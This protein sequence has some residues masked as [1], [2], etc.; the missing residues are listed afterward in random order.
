M[1]RRLTLCALVIGLVS[2]GAAGGAAQTL[3]QRGFA[4]ARITLFP[5][6]T[7]T[8]RVRAMADVMVREEVF[9][10]PTVWL[11]LAAGLDLRQNT[12]DQV[13][14]R[15]DIGDRGTLRPAASVR[16]LAATIARG[17]FTI[18]I[19]K[20][21]IRWGKADIVTPTD[22]FAPRDF[23]NVIDTEF[24]GVS[25]AR[26]VVQLG[27]HTVDIVW[28]RFTPSRIPI[29][30]Q[31][32]AQVS[33]SSV[34]APATGGVQVPVPVDGIEAAIPDGSQAGVRYSRIGRIEYSLSV[35]DGF[36]YLPNIE[37]VPGP[38][39]GRF[40]LLRRYPAMRS[41]GGDAG[42][43]MRYFTVKA[44]AAYSTSDTPATDD[45][46]LYVVQLE[47]L[48]GEWQFAGGYAGEVVTARRAAATF[49]PDRGLTR[50]I[51]ARA[52]YTIDSNRSVA[53][54]GAARQNGRGV[55]TKVEYSQARGQHWRGTIT[56]VIIA[57][58]RD[59]F[60]G[61]YNRNSHVAAGLRYSF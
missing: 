46:V 45:Y 47:R 16:R 41:Y 7:P 39:P 42:V 24:L 60:L 21:F 51:V 22:R 36:N 8:D 32:W 61:Q 15:L 28:T 50:S 3:S 55:Y 2:A 23:L 27:A 43:P 59:D 6:D 13:E 44:E 9:A 48:S 18:D 31:R 20:Q 25:G 53:F 49:A 35:F 58:S 10:K 5:Q 12:H 30:N 34:P 57:G 1:S 29:L 33:A 4:D 19:G 11:Q 17:P 52:G 56:G 14:M 54:E 37:A 26:G 40:Q 38:Q